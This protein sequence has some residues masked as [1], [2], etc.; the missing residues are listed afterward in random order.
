VA[1]VPQRSHAWL[2]ADGVNKFAVLL[3]Q[4][5]SSG[6]VVPIRRSSVILESRLSLHVKLLKLH[7]ESPAAQDV[8]LPE[9]VRLAVINHGGH[10]RFIDF[11]A[12]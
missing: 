7:A 8:I 5:I 3:A 1:R 10:E 4:D 6:K 9:G 11:S 12:A 2:S